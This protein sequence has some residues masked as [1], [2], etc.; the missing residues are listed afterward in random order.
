M[1]ALAPLSFQPLRAGVARQLSHLLAELD[2]V[3]CCRVVHVE[4]ARQYE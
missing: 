3:N 1:I 2:D 4:N